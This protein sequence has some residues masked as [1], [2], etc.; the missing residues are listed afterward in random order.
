MGWEDGVLI[1]G[2]TWFLHFATTSTE[3]T[4]NFLSEQ[5]WRLHGK[6]QTECEA[7]ISLSHP[8]NCSLQ[9]V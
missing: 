9:S 3:S 4:G 1:P 6:K 5:C 2:S 7:K 8:Q